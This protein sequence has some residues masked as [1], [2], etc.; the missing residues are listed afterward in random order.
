M[1]RLQR[2]KWR[3]VLVQK[4]IDHVEKGVNGAWLVNLHGL[5]AQIKR[6]AG[7]L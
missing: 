2:H 3:S 7:V 4:I 1:A 6:P 5:R